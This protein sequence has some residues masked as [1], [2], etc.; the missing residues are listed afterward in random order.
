VARPT[1]TVTGDRGGDRPLRVVERALRGP[2]DRRGDGWRDRVV[3]VPGGHRPGQPDFAQRD[4]ARALLQVAGSR[5]IVVLGCTVGAGQTMTT[6]MTGE[7][8]ARIRDEPVAVLDLNSGSGSLAQRAGSMPA[9]AVGPSPN[10][11][12]QGSRPQP[13][14]SQL[15]VIGSEALAGHSPGEDSGRSAARVLELLSARYH[16]TL[17]DPGAPAVPRVLSIADQLLLVAPASADAARAIAM[18][19]EWLE[20]HGHAELGS[21]SITV[22][23]GVSRP[24]MG[25]VEQA[26]AVARGRCRAIV[27]VPWDDQLRLHE[28][29]PGD[30]LLGPAAVQAYTALAGV[31]VAGLATA[32]EP[33]RAHPRQAHPRQAH[34]RQA[35]PRQAQL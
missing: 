21:G 15:A 14:P 29:A 25:Y 35:H 23:N 7:I 19:M 20:A 9:V 2:S 22:I 3:V 5:R 16:L 13:R 10:G 8:L 17:A 24:T 31:L 4:R 26:E 28:D 34:P 30:R 11:P 1:V 18:T 32:P 33:R 6:L 27:R 12:G